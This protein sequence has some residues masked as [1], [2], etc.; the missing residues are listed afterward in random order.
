MFMQL[1]ALVILIVCK[2][3]F[4][5]VFSFGPGVRFDQLGFHFYF[6]W[7]VVD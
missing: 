1:S 4:Q 7:R 6:W 2:I 3:M 5:G